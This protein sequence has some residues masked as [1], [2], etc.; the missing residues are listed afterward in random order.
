MFYVSWGDEST[1]KSV[2]VI[3]CAWSVL[4]TSVLQFRKIENSIG[5]SYLPFGLFS[6]R[7]IRDCLK[8]GLPMQHFL[9]VTQLSK[10]HISEA[11]SPKVSSLPAE[12]VTY[13]T[14]HRERYQ[15]SN[16][17]SV[18]LPNFLYGLERRD[19]PTVYT[20]KLPSLSTTI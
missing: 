11:Y 9:K 13:D 15:G 14:C 1:L 18:F 16:F 4:R 12:S 19:T 8:H 6:C 7:K 20:S 17:P 10:K 2:V 5:C 3:L